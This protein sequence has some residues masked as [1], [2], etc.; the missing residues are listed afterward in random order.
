LV[1]AFLRDQDYFA[2][3]FKEE[4]F[5]YQ[6][7]DEFSVE[8]QQAVEQKL[9]E[10]LTRTL[11]STPVGDL[12]PDLQDQVR[13]RL[14]QAGYFVDQEQLEQVRQLPVDDLP[15][16]LR[17]AVRR[18][19]GTYL[20]EHQPVQNQD[21]RS[22]EGVR[23]ADLSEETRSLL[24]R[25]LDE[26][27][28]FVDEKK[29][30]QFL[31]RRLID[32]TA[33]TYEGIVQ[34]LVSY[35]RSEIGDQPVSDLNEELRQGL[36][37]ALEDLGYF[38]S[39]TVRAEVLSQ[40][41]SAVRRDDQDALAAEVG[42]D[43]LKATS[44]RRLADLPAAEQEEV[45]SHLQSRG[46]FLDQGRHERVQ[47][48]CVQDLDQGIRHD[49]V[50]RLKDQFMMRTEGRRL[51]RMDRGQQHLIRSF[52]RQRGLAADESEIRPLRH[53]AIKDLEREVYYDLLRDLGG[54][55]LTTW[56]EASFQDLPSEE[57]A[58][59][60]AY[61][62]RRIM[63]RIERRV[64][65]HTISRLWID[66]LTDI[67]DLRRGIGLEAY[68]QRDPL[69]EYKRRAFELFAELGDNIRRTVVRSL[70]RQPPEPLASS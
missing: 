32:L 54:E 48:L 59:L 2:D 31:E 52:L 46:W 5:A 39:E 3:E 20:L 63:G 33:E 18:V 19:L 24:W 9:A 70:F 58:Q 16:E 62:G 27:G 29:Q 45:L 26:I 8:A 6:R 64:L 1:W 43:R 49:L 30:A 56:D 55:V 22:L 13:S 67:E 10:R 38:E 15:V 14:Q 66:Y 42:G 11:A 68:G 61:L 69:V 35:L 28:Y 21:G 57:Q 40:P 47:A 50:A 60:S 12:S 36:R 41:V 44:A 53:R 4:L 51:S 7:L 25:Y 65:L 37:E 34:D 23:V 17:D